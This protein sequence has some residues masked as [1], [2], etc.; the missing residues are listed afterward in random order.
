MERRYRECH[1][2]SRITLQ[3]NMAFQPIRTQESGHVIKAGY[4][5]ILCILTYLSTRN[6]CKDIMNI[7]PTSK[8]TLCP[9]PTLV[10]GW[11]SAFGQHYGPCP[12]ADTQPDTQV[13]TR[14]CTPFSVGLIYIY[15]M[16]PLSWYPATYSIH[17]V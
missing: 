5:G 7:R 9:V 13:D 11:V 15:L 17:Y 6:L 14:P 4:Q 12:Q 10:S 3:C 1:N 8:G 16:T 2:Q